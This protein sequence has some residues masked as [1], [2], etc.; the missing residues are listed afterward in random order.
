MLVLGASSVIGA[1]VYLVS[2]TA[3][4][5]E[6]TSPKSASSKPRATPTRRHHDA[7]WERSTAHV[8]AS[9]ARRSR[10]PALHEVLDE[11][12]SSAS[13]EPMLDAPVVPEDIEQQLIERKQDSLE[14]LATQATDSTWAAASRSQ[15]ST[16]L[17]ELAASNGFAITSVECKTSA[18]L[19][20]LELGEEPASPRL[21]ALLAGTDYGLGCASEVWLDPTGE[22]R[23]VELILKHCPRD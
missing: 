3:R 23:R 10:S 22:S 20:E 2:H 13:P 21:S 1:S 7:R 6:E 16:R 14:L 8:V 12:E 5:G 11:P 9:S 19:A 18:C 17:D 15:V 4:S